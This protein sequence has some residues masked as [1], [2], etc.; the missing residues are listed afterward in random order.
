MG[1]TFFTK[2]SKLLA[3]PAMVVTA[4]TYNSG[5][6]PN[7]TYGM[8]GRVYG[9]SHWMGNGL[10][11]GIF[12]AVISLIFWILVIFGIVYLIK[13]LIRGRQGGEQEEETQE[14]LKKRYAKGEISKEE[15][16]QM[17]KELDKM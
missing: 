10:G 15:Y 12:G 9:P 6:C 1:E 11:L 5:Y 2:A 3:S 14:I 4:Q 16:D 7:W 8:M 13:Y 17:K